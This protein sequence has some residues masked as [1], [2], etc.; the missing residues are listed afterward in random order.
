MRYQHDDDHLH[1]ERKDNLLD[2]DE[3]MEEGEDE[4][5]AAQPVLLRQALGFGGGTMLVAGMVDLFA[6]LGPTG[7]VVGG[8]AAYVAARHGPQLYAQ[9]RDALFPAS[10]FS[11]VSLPPPRQAGEER[12][13]RERQSEGSR[14]M[15]DRALGRFPEDAAAGDE[16]TTGV[17]EEAALEQWQAA[18][19]TPFAQVAFP[20]EVPGVPR[21]TL[22]QIVAHTEPNSYSV[23]LGRSLTLPRHPAVK[24]SFFKRHLKLLG[25][26]QHGKSSMA[27]FLLDAIARTHEPQRVQFALLDLEDKTGRLFAH[28]PHVARVKKDGQL[29]RLHAR[30][31]EQVLLHL[32]YLSALIDYRYALSEEEL[33]RQPLVIVYLEEF[34][35][36]KDYFKQR[37]EAAAR[38]ERE[39]ARADYARLVFCL[40][41]LARRGLKVRVQLL[42]CAHVDYR[43]DDLQEAL[44]NITSG[45]AFCVRVSAAQAAGFYQSDLLARNARENRVGQ[46]VVEMPDCKDLILAPQYDLKARLSGLARV[47]RWREQQ[48]RARSQE[49]WEH[50]TG[51]DGND[52]P[53]RNGGERPVEPVYGAV[54]AVPGV[55]NGERSVPATLEAVGGE[56]R[57]HIIR[58]ARAGVPRR[59][60]CL[61]LGTGKWSYDVVKQ[62]LDEEGL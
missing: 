23:Y 35:D 33:E 4:P 60:M 40:K 45:M 46:A 2:E 34:L 13:R 38:E 6:H 41:K 47:E 53:G 24:I 59:E 44:I 32:G 21:L 55:P 50:A 10:S 22:E 11:S 5:E 18:E 29:I 9:A 15:L 16:D 19:D 20:T 28:L 52:F 36:L 14:S 54:P 43:D 61:K 3:E 57:E 62:V 25:A 49:Q 26:S 42:L 58:L 39:Q 1:D 31:Y 37:V 8:I 27:A 12:E 7:L 51:T 56:E 30:S 48:Q 17:S